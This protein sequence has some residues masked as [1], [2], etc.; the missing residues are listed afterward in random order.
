[1]GTALPDRDRATYRLDFEPNR[2]LHVRRN[3]GSG[4]PL[5]RLGGEIDL[6]ARH[7]HVA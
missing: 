2:V 5:D 1:M 7:E 6:R 3:L 4:V